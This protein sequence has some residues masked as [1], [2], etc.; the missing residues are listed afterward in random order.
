[1]RL[2]ASGAGVTRDAPYKRAKVSPA[3][4]AAWTRAREDAIDML[5]AEARRRAL[6]VSDTL[7]MFLLRAHRPA[8]YRDNARL[9]LTGAA[10]GP[11]VTQQVLS[12]L[13][14][15][16]KAALRKAIDEVLAKGPS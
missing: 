3:F 11:I 13:D 6:S 1:M 8:V 5:E 10:G 15:H 12:D 2:A 9:E 14:D 4:A 7:L 16:D